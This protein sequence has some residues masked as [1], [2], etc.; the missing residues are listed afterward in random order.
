M[1]DDEEDNA[2]EEQEEDEDEEGEDSD[3]VKV[4]E[5][6]CQECEEREGAN[7]RPIRLRR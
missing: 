7:H 6:T 5:D 3:A 2:E 4:D 1:A